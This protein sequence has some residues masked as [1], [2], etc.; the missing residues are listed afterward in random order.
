MSDKLYYD[1]TKAPNIPPGWITVQEVA[2]PTSGM[3][4]INT[5]V[6]YSK[7]TGT[8]PD[9]KVNLKNTIPEDPLTTGISVIKKSD[10]GFVANIYFRITSSDGKVNEIIKTDEA[11]SAHLDGLDVCTSDGKRLSTRQVNSV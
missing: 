7:V 6:Y 9:V 3:Y 4:E 5:Q 10:D 1:D 2:A 11:G 8:E